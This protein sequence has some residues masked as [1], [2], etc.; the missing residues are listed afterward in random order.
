MSTRITPF[1]LQQRFELRTK[2]GALMPER[3]AKSPNLTNRHDID[4]QLR[5]TH[6]E[7]DLQ[8]L[9]FLEE[10][11]IA[12]YHHA[13]NWFGGIEGMKFDLWVAPDLVDLQYMLGLACPETFFC[14]PGVRGGWRIV[15]GLSP[16]AY[17]NPRRPLRYTGCLV[18]EISH[19]IIR[20]KAGATLLSMRRRELGDLPMWVEEGLCQVVECE[21]DADLAGG[22]QERIRETRKRLDFEDLWDDLSFCEEAELAYLQAYQAIQ[23]LLRIRGKEYLLELLS[24]NAVRK[25]DWRAVAG[26]ALEG[27]FEE[28]EYGKGAK[29][30]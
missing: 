15:A 27:R 7:A 22:L 13:K 23:E 14:A 29:L 5:I 25:V 1:L 19:H 16:R 10:V 21:L 26:E 12:A 30:S 24:M 20:E 11:F 3:L 8:V 6:A 17:Q 18:H 4:D 28:A 2:F 9:P